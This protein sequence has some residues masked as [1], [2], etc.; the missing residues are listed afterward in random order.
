MTA[1]EATRL[2]KRYG[3]RW[4]LRA[5]DLA[6]PAGRVVALVGSN[7]AGKTTLLEIAVGL[8]RPTAGA[9]RLFGAAPGPRSLPTVGF[10]AQISGWSS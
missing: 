7:G 4:A 10:V 5:V 3:R 2:G 9:V 8:I 6:I 1:V